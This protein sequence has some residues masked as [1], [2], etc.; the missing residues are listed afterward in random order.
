MGAMAEQD[1][2]VLQVSRSAGEHLER[3][4]MA[5]TRNRQGEPPTGRMGTTELLL[6]LVAGLFP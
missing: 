1:T 6:N 3:Q 2:T 4:E 5:G